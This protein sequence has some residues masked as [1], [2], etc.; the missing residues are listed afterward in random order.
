MSEALVTSSIVAPGFYGLNTQESSIELNNGYAL[1]A[2]NVVIDKSGRVGS[3]KGWKPKHTTLAALGSNPVRGIYELIANDGT[4]YILAVGNNKLFKLV[5]TTL[6]E[7]TYGG[8]GTAPTI[9]ANNWSIAALNDK[10]Y[11]FQEGHSP[12]VFNPIN[13]IRPF[14]NRISFAFGCIA[15]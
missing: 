2:F 1:Q 12:L 4:K 15:S 11:F 8:G 9:T 7:L 14:T 10:V 13:F 6:S 3:R 5:G